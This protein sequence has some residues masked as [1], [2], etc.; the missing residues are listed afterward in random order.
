[1]E[2]G[3]ERMLKCEEQRLLK[4]Q[5]D[6][7][8]RLSVAIDGTLNITTSGKCVQYI[9]YKRDLSNRKRQMTY[10][11]KSDTATIK[12]LAQKSYDKKIKRLVD[13]RLKQI[14]TLCSEYRENEI[15]QIYE[16]LS[17][18][19]KQLIDPVEKLWEQQV[20]EWKS[21][22]YIG[23]E[24]SDDIPLIYSAKGERVRSKS[25]KILA[26][27][28]LKMG[29]EYKYECPIELKGYGVVYPDFTF[30]SR[31][32]GKEIYWEHEGRM[33]DPKYADKAVRK[34]DTYI[35]NKI[36]PGVNLILTFETSKCVLSDNTIKEMIRCFS[37]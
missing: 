5:K 10:I 22:P 3:L 23:K 36:I 26:D 27:T 34:I 15:L 31:K 24:F 7:N 37:L 13:R 30:L 6:V 2:K 9:H 20:A 18:T 12:A 35:N 14:Q 33:D 25:E 19:R 32:T 11:S 28:F 1:M 29:I 4:I 17:D 21:V 16:S 8:D